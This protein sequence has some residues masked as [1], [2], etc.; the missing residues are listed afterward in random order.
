MT[1]DLVQARLERS[2]VMEFEA[3]V[4]AVENFLQGKPRLVYE[5]SGEQ[6][7]LDCD[8]VAGCDGFHGVARKSVDSNRSTEYEKVY[9]FGWPAA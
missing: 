4:V 8:F 1:R 3:P 6:H 5:Q 2:G 9:P 7:E